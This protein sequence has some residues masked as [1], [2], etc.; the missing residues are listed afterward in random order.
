[1]ANNKQVTRAPNWKEWKHTSEVRVWQACALS[2][3]IEPRSMQA[4]RDGWM[5]G[6]D[7][8]P[9]FEPE[10]FPNQ[11]AE[12]E[13]GVR[14]RVLCAN[15]SNREFFS[16]GDISMTTPGNHG[17][18]LSEFSEWAVSEVGWENLPPEL[19]AMAQK[20]EAQAQ[21]P[22]DSKPTAIKPVQRA[23]AQN[24]AIIEAIRAKNIEPKKIPKAPSGK[25][26]LKAEIRKDILQTH[27]DIFSSNGVFNDAW[28]RLRSSREI[29]DA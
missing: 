8:G 17:V 18:R 12:E 25:P 21:L 29:I 24:A 23:A 19:V 6:S 16:P 15:L 2:L 28:Q 4:S 1:M 9:C 14:Q 26:G 13:F 7:N 11:D 3:G 20:R 5:G 10:S 27:K 22:A